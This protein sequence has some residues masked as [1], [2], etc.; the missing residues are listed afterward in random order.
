[1]V[2]G[3]ITGNYGSGIGTGCAIGAAT[4]VLMSIR[5]MRRIKEE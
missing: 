1:V 4:A 5:Y 2:I 3:L